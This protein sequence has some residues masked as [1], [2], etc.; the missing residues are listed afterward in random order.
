MTTY[1]HIKTKAKSKGIDTR[2]DLSGGYWLTDSKGNDLYDNDNFSSTLQ[3][4]NN[5]VE[6]YIT[7]EAR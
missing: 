7:M 3:E 2:K 6:N 1:Q 5:K 4:L